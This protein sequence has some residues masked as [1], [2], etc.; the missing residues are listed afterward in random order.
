M[1]A[2][3]FVASMLLVSVLMTGCSI[4]GTE[5]VSPDQLK[6]KA[7]QLKQTAQAK[8]DELKNDPELQNKLMSVAGV[9][10]EQVDQWLTTLVKDPVI[11]KANEQLGEDVVQQVIEEMVANNRG[12]MDAAAIVLIQKEL[13]KR[14]GQ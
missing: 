7:D 3:A 1:K 14:M 8:L 6:E 5:V 13:E 4:G 12:V 2:K 9:S 11:A 10:Q